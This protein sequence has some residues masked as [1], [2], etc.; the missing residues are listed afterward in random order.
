MSVLDD[1]LLITDMTFTVLHY[2]FNNNN[3]NNN[4]NKSEF[5]IK[6]ARLKM[7]TAVK[8]E[9]AWSSETLV[10]YHITIHCHNPEDLD[11]Y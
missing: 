5:G 6:N 7:F 1:L 11:H 10:S 8:M 3:N 4:N 2:E 9:A